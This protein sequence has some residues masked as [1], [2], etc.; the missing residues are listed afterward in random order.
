MINNNKYVFIL[1]TKK[2]HKGLKYDSII[3]NNDYNYIVI[4]I[5]LLIVSSRHYLGVFY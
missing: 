1:N 4:V 5:L 2:I 3:S